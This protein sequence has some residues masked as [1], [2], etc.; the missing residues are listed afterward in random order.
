MNKP[1]PKQRQAERLP[2]KGAK[3]ALLTKNGVITGVIASW[4]GDGAVVEVSGEGVA[5]GLA[6]SEVRLRAQGPDRIWEKKATVLW[7]HQDQAV[8]LEFEPD[9]PAMKGLVQR[10]LDSMRSQT[11]EAR[12]AVQSS[13]QSLVEKERLGTRETTTDLRRRRRIRIETPAEIMRLDGADAGAEITTITDAS[14]SGVLFTTNRGYSVGTKLLIKYPYPNSSL[15]RQEGNVV[16]V[17]RL[18]DGR[19]RVAVAFGPAYEKPEH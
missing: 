11:T 7:V 15:P 2:G 4:S 3:A 13:S 8:G 19:R 9:N 17:E 12:A 18:P 1:D 10:V 6:G 14:S 5:G 16:R